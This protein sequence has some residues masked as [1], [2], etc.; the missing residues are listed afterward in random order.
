MWVVVLAYLVGIFIARGV[1]CSRAGLSAVRGFQ[2]GG[3]D[4]FGYMFALR[5]GTASL[6]WPLALAVW[7]LRGRPEP[8]LV[9]DE[10]ARRLQAQELREQEQLGPLYRAARKSGGAAWERLR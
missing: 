4:G 1:I 3:P 5:V 10:K 8:K 2:V 9:F 6:F 7:L